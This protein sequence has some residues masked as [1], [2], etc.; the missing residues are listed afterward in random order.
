MA[1]LLPPPLEKD[2]FDLLPFQGNVHRKLQVIGFVAFLRCP[3]YRGR[4]PTPLH[5]N[6]VL[7]AA[8]QEIGLRPDVL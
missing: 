1:E 6:E 7:S 5:Q 2:E 8:V 3:Y 4:T